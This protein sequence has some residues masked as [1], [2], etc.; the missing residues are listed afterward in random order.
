MMMQEAWS[1]YGARFRKY[2]AAKAVQ[3][4]LAG[5]F[6]MPFNM[7]LHKFQVL[8]PQGQPPAVQLDNVHLCS[9]VAAP[10]AV[11]LAEQTAAE[12]G[13]VFPDASVSQECLQKMATVHLA[14]SKL[15]TSTEFVEQN[16]LC[17]GQAGWLKTWIR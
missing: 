8:Q 6:D 3:Q 5:S 9:P 12:L 11:T 10:D 17:L 4:L 16:G 7:G 15:C 13:I 2:T 1:I 14:I